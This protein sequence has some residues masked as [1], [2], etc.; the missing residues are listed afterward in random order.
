MQITD[1]VPFLRLD[2]FSNNNL[3]DDVDVVVELEEINCDG[4]DDL[5]P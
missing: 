1:S 3:L 5:P 4:I 2:F